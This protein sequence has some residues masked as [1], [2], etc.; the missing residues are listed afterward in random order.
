[1]DERYDLDFDLRRLG[2]WSGLDLAL[3]LDALPLQA[4]KLA[5]PQPVQSRRSWSG[6]VWPL[7]GGSDNRLLLHLWRWNPLGLGAVLVALVLVLSLALQHL[8][9]LLGFGLPE[10]PG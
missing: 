5:A 3:E 1:V 10:L 6:L 4:V 8:R 9:R 2:P 7:Q